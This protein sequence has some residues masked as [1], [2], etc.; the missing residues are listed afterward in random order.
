MRKTSQTSS[1]RPFRLTAHR[2]YHSSVLIGGLISSLASPKDWE[3]A[4][5]KFRQ[6]FG[7]YLRQEE[8]FLAQSS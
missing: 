6:A 8:H 2:K 4:P 1:A 3:Q 7:P 5:V